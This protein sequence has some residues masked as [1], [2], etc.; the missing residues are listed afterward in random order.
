M[1]VWAKILYLLVFLSIIYGTGM[2]LHKRQLEK[3]QKE[4]NDEKMVFF[5][6]VA[7]EIKTP[8][9]LVKSPMEDIL[10]RKKW[11]E[12]TETDL[13]IMKKNIDRLLE[14]VCQLLD[15]RKIDS[16]DIVLSSENLDLRRLSRT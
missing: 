2:L 3:R 16:G 8:L 12:D 5:T 1:T 9:S 11:D 10:D 4:M 7:H 15:F 13:E 14:L 6:Q